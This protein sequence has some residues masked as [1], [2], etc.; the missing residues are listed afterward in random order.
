L[1]TPKPTPIVILFVLFLLLSTAGVKAQQSDWTRS[2]TAARA[3][4]QSGDY[5]TALNLY[6]LT[7]AS[8]EKALGPNHAQVAATLNNL[9]VLYHN[10]GSY[11]Q[12]EPLYKRSLTIWEKVPEK[13]AQVVAALNNLASMYR[14]QGRNA[15]AVALYN[16]A[17]GIWQKSG[18][19]DD[20]RAATAFY[21]LGS[22]YS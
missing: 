10:Q 5:S 9:A 13:E 19:I 11:S 1:K 21:N 22:I 20:S 3:A 4:S 14:D 6:K 12:A 18:H 2:L 16:R 7:L 15:E 17:L 8:Q